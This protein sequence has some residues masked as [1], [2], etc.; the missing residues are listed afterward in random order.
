M[1]GLPFYGCIMTAGMPA[2]IER[3]KGYIDAGFALQE[4]NPAG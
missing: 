4:A 3:E 1:A 2:V